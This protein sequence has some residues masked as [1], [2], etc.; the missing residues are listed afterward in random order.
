MFPQSAHLLRAAWIVACLLAAPAAWAEPSVALPTAEGPKTGAPA[1]LT[2]ALAGGLQAQGIAVN[3][4]RDLESAE[5]SG[6]D[7]VAILKITKVKKKHTLDVRLNRGNGTLVKTLRI[8]YKGKADAAA[9]GAGLAE[10]LAEVIKAEAPPPAPP[11]PKPVVRSEPPPPPPPPT[12][13]I[14]PDVA[15]KTE[16]PS[17][18]ALG[19][20]DRLFRLQLGFG[21]QIASAY[22]VAVGGEVT[23]LAYDLSPL[24]LIDASV[25][26][27]I[28]NLGL[29][30]D[31]DFSFVPVKY[32]ID[33]D[34]PV[35]PSE[36]GGRF[37][38]VGG[39]VFYKLRLARFGEGG[40]F[41]LTPLLGAGYTSLTVESQ[42]ENTVVVS[43]SAIDA[44]LGARFGIQISEAAAIELDAKGGLV[45]AYSEGPT[46]TGDS[47]SGLS[48]RVGGQGRYWLAGPMGLYLSAVY[49]YQKI[50][51]SGEG[52]RT[53]FVGDPELIDASVFSGDFKLSGGVVLAL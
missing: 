41:S 7:F 40:S 48:L 19:R 4:V 46:T 49:H 47:G 52:T 39:D 53:P 45:L 42:G 20:E 35:D 21:T 44:H 6:S 31:L 37:L 13:T 38:N 50:G 25:L 3:T 33:V 22:T 10:T 26:L 28:P 1:K 30:L 12:S 16:A 15:T 34:P 2:K 9:I 5:S 27:Q 14:K 43:W 24:L 36:P 51:L 32:S 18:V 11:P 23:G 17:K 29:G 8:S